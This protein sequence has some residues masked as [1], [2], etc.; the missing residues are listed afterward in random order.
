VR[1]QA[2]CGIDQQGRLRAHGHWLVQFVSERTQHHCLYTVPYTG[3]VWWNYF[4]LSKSVIPHMP[5]LLGADQ[6]ADSTRAAPRAFAEVQA[7]L[8]RNTVF[9]LFLALRNTNPYNAGRF[10]WEAHFMT[11]AAEPQERKDI[12]LQFDPVT[13]DLLGATTR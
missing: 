3:S 4:H 12:I 9:D 7:H 10:V 8:G 2:G 5:G 6:W 1:D 11:V 13:V